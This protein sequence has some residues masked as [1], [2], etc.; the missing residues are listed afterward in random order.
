MITPAGVGCKRMLAGVHVAMLGRRSVVERTRDTSLAC[1]VV[2][3][4]IALPTR[5]PVTHRLVVTSWFDVDRKD[6]IVL[7]FEGR[8][9]CSERLK[10]PKSIVARYRIRKPHPQGSMARTLDDSKHS[11]P[12]FGTFGP[13]LDYV[14]MVQVVRMK[15]RIA[16]FVAVIAKRT[17]P[18][19]LATSR[20]MIREV[21]ANLDKLLEFHSV[22]LTC[23][24][25][26]ASRAHQL[27]PVA[28]RADARRRLQRP[29]RR[30]LQS[31]K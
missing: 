24:R 15:G 27:F 23:C 25:S 19:R 21:Y 11:R 16:E 7:P 18:H 29:V 10:P 17:R 31:N 6:R 8:A 13:R 26:A 5:N 14:E 4:A 22:R 1:L 9:E 2:E 20:P 28:R 12:L 30:P 3:S